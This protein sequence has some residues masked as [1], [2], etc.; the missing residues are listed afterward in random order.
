MPASSFINSHQFGSQLTLCSQNPKRYSS[1]VEIPSTFTNFRIPLLRLGST[2][3]FVGFDPPIRALKTSRTFT[4]QFQTQPKMI[5][6][7]GKSELK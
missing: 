5:R 4:T 6:D 7:R 1:S 2:Q 3:C